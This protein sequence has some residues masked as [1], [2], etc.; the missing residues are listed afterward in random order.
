MTIAS[1]IEALKPHFGDRLSTAAAIREQHG[2]DEAWH[3]PSPPDAVI[4]PH[5]T[6]EVSQIA[7]T[8]N[9]HGCP[10]IAWGAGTSLEGHVIPVQGGITLDFSEMSKILAVHPEDMDVTVQPGITRKR[11]NEELRETGLFSPI[12]PGADATIGGMAGTRASG[13]CAVRYGTMREN[14]LGLTAV[15]A[16]GS[17][18]QTGGRARKSAA[19]YDLTHLLC[20]SEGTLGVITEVH[21]RCHGLPE[22]NAVAVCAFDSLAGA[23]NSVIQIIQYGIPI[24]RVELLDDVQIDA[25]NRYSKLDLPV[26]H[27]LFFEF[28]GTAAGVNEQTE[29]VRDIVVEHG[30]GDFSWSTQTVQQTELWQARHDAYY[31]ALALKP[32]VEGWPTDVCVP[33]SKLTQCILDTRDDVARQ[34]VTAPIVGHVGDGNFH[35][36]LLV[37]PN[38]QEDVAVAHEIND[39]LVKRAINMGG[40]C[41]GEHGIGLGKLPY[42]ALEHGSAL[43]VMRSIKQALD[44]HNL[45][46][47]GKV[48]PGLN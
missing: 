2:K 41:T 38:N 43:P 6:E 22:A 25:V 3:K 28:H 12:A 8:C 10:I 16:D 13:T 9:Q 17:V 23:V 46:N 5:S 45:L 44:P 35:L 33:L 19:G 18:I 36:L 34:G 26:A 20:G 24:A 11:L 37:D 7:R 47:P 15:M 32:N 14:L 39:R 1:A 31:A 27:T 48:I 30:G 42:M 4:W 21:L 40:T 29:L